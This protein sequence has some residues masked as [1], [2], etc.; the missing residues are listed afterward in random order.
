MKKFFYLLVL[1]LII[2]TT[3]AQETS[4]IVGGETKPAISRDVNEKESDVI[5]AL[6]YYF[7]QK[8]VKKFKKS[9]GIYTVK[10][11]KI[12]EITND[13]LDLFF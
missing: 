2:K 8:G 3:N 4:I 5:D 1:M 10:G 13:N 7:Q 12:N 9:K 11:I 6:K